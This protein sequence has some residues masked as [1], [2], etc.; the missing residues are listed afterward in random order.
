MTNIEKLNDIFIEVFN[1][2][3]SV[4][5]DNFGKNSVENWDS[6]H[7]L[8]LTSFIEEEFDIMLDAEDILECISYNNAKVILAKYGIKF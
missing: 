8:S 4:L 1:V 6:I 7:Q 3:V 5:N 2:E